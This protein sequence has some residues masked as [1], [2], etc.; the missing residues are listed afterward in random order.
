M[1][2]RGSRLKLPERAN[3]YSHVNLQSLNAVEEFTRIVENNDGTV[4]RLLRKKW[5]SFE[6]Y[7]DG[8]QGREPGETD[9]EDVDDESTKEVALL[10]RQSPQQS[11]GQGFGVN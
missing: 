9:L 7:D 11:M 3:A 10:R 6:R 5:R 1:Y 2:N 8:V 4:K